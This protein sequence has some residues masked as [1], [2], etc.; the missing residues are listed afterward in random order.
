MVTPAQIL[1]PYAHIC[2]LIAAPAL[3]TLP[4]HAVPQETVTVGFRCQATPPIGAPQ[5][6]NLDVDVTGDAPATA[7]TGDTVTLIITPA[8]MTVPADVSG[9]QVQSIRGL[10]LL[11][12][13]P[14]NSSHLST[15]VSG[16][17]VPASST[18]TD[19]TT[20]VAIP[21]PIPGGASVTL[22]TVTHSV[23]GHSNSTITT[24]LAGTGHHDPGLTFT[25]TIATFIGS[26]DIP[27]ACYP[28]PAPT[29]T[30]TITT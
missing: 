9:Y 26:I 3:S 17:T 2:A 12:P 20:V 14:A 11:V 27:V 18:R 15:T 6:F 13:H 22:P 29:L 25:A 16:G 28:D 21:G 7:T 30:T 23:R 8:E 19:D 5:E 24:T 4:A 1:P 10:R